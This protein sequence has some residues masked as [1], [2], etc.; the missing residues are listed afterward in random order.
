MNFL[1]GAI[2]HQQ[3]D[4]IEGWVKSASVHCKDAKKILFCLDKDIPKGFDKIKSLGIELIHL[5]TNEVNGTDIVKSERFH[6]IWEYLRKIE[7]KKSI[8]LTTDTLD[9]CFQSDPFEWYA[10]NKKNELLLGSEG[11]S[12]QREH[13]NHRN[14]KSKFNHYFDHVKDNDVLCCGVIM[15]EVGIVEDLILHMFGYARLFKSEDNE[16]GDQG[17]MNVILLSNYFKSKLQVTTSSEPMII[18]CAT[19]GPTDLFVSWGFKDNYKYD[20][21]KFDGNNVVNKD[22]IP[23]CIVHQYNRVKE[24]EKFFNEKHRAIKWP[25]V[26]EEPIKYDPKIASDVAVVVCTKVN[27]SYTSDWEKVLSFNNDDYMLCDVS[28]KKVPTLDTFNK[29]VPDNVI[30][31]N[32]TYL[33]GALNFKEELSNKHWWNLGG[34]RN[35]IWFYP[36]FRMLYFYMLHPEY[37]FYWFFD[38]DVTW[39]NNQLNDFVRAH[40]TLD[41]DCM[42]SYIFSHED[43]NLQPDTLGMGKPM[44]SYH[45]ADCTWLSHYP[46]EGDKQHPDVKKNYGSYFPLVGLSNKSMSTL[47]EYHKRGFYGYSEGYVPTMLA[48]AGLKLYSIYNK[49]SKMKVDEN[50]ISWHRRY[51]QMTWENI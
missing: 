39:P 27:S 5:P 49:D 26:S 45:A 41:H 46:G 18:H 6:I 33:R 7:D 31:Y 43:Q 1:I 51:H 22:N 23:Y 42:I 11:I 50:L 44:V 34:N 2:K 4:R 25:D 16:G 29:F 21:P 9:V 10:N 38:D 19:A 17:A 35:I 15:G 37:K 24:W 30:N 20:L 48:H 8:V 28:S 13:W 14:I 3:L 36:H 47:L 12:I 32:E 40:A